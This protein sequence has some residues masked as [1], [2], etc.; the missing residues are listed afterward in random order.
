[1]TQNQVVRFGRYRLDANGLWRRSHE[2]RL[3][4]KALA[5]LRVLVARAGQVVSK[6]EL[7]EAVWPDTA[8]SD[9]A[10]SSCIQELRQ[11]LHDD[12]RHPR[13]LETVHRRGYRFALVS[14]DEPLPS[15]SAPGLTFRRSPDLVG[16]EW[17]LQ[18]L[19][20]WLALAEQGERQ[21]VFVTGDPGIGKTTLVEAFL[22]E[23]A[24]TSAW[25]IGHGQC[26]EHYGAGEAYLPVLESLGRLCREADGERIVQVLAR[27]APT[28]LGQMPSL[29]SS[30]ELR[31]IQRRTQ[32]ATRAR[33]LRELTEAVEVLSAARPLVLRLEDLHW[34]DASTLDWLAF[35]ARR[36]ERARLLLIGI[37]RPVEVLGRDHPL[38]AVKHELQLHR[39]CRELAVRRLDDAAV[40]EYLVRRCPVASEDVLALARL[41]R[42]ISARTEG[43]PLFMVNAVDDLIAR[44]GLV[45]RRGRWRLTQPPDSVPVTVPADVCQMIARQLAWLGPTEQRLLEAASIA[46]A[47]FSAAVV[48][49]A[50]A[51]D[52]ADVEMR[53]AELARREQLVGESGTE[54][55]PDGTIAARYAFLHALY[56]EVL[57]ERVPEGVRAGLH[58]RVGTRLE[59]AYG[60]RS[61]DIAAELA[62]HFDRSGDIDRAVR[63]LE[64][65]GTIAIRWN[66]PR[67]AVMHLDRA[68]ALLA[69]L[70]DT[71][72]RIEHELSLQIALGSQLMT[73]GGWGAPEV[74]RVYARAHALCGQAT[75]PARLFP[76]LWGLLLFSLGRGDVTRARTIAEDLLM[77]AERTGDP[78]LLLQ[79]HHALWSTLLSVGEFEA[80]H[81]HAT[82]GIA[83]YD[84]ETHAPLASI[85]G[86]HDAGVCARLSDAWALLLLGFPDHA[87]DAVY[88]AIALAEHLGHPFNLALAHLRAAIIHQERRE[89]D[90]VRARADTATALAREHGFR[91]VSGRATGL[92]GWVVAIEGRQEDG[93]AELRAA[94]SG[95]VGGA[96]Q[97][98]SYLLALLADACLM[99]GRVAEGL[100]A[101]AEGLA[102]ATTTGERFYE[103]ELQRLRGQLLVCN[104]R[105]AGAEA[106]FLAA[107]E[108]ARLQRARWLERRAAMSLG[109][110]WQQQGRAE[111]ACRLLID[112]RGWFTE[113]PDT[114]DGIVK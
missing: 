71:P 88:D 54:R 26:V 46:G 69:T 13:Y 18:E 51:A 10:L 29:I 22:A 50:A 90:A 104:E 40:Q 109:R 11:A 5:V 1:V 48:A 43:H 47:E 75:D 39:H 84:V 95:P 114:A 101:V 25:R 100:A 99:A 61:A 16:R 2:V 57:Y 28:W 91:L 80:A 82:R 3:T 83:L 92:L 32:P 78:D 72:A 17:E 81:D 86:N 67:E 20:S 55:W 94:A 98:Q 70:P 12:A 68:I 97:F 66:A 24:A 96:D 102:R 35:L 77:R 23:V 74:E 15:A 110:L 64:Q 106:C 89:P 36:P 59:A 45:E 33:M 38:D 42:A 60:T 73:T 111:E 9:A 8:V 7:F 53:F 108:V 112:V 44:G 30:A 63:Y 79:A 41:A 4:P 34:S 49:A 19:R 52:P 6:Q 27:Y 113:G 37:Y 58:A 76:A 65:A 56:R 105:E 85:Y 31:A 21:V 87:R 107:I 93:I 103:A 14:T 62:M